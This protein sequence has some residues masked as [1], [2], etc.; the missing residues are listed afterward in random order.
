MEDIKVRIYAFLSGVDSLVDLGIN[1]NNALE[2]TRLD[3]NGITE[4]YPYV[5]ASEPLLYFI[6]QDS[7]RD[8]EEEV[9]NEAIEMKNVAE[10]VLII[11]L[12][13]IRIIEKVKIVVVNY[14][15]DVKTM[16]GRLLKINDPDWEKH[17]SDLQIRLNGYQPPT[18]DQ[19]PTPPPIHEMDDD[20]FLFTE[21]RPPVLVLYEVLGLTPQAT[22]KEIRTAYKNL[23][24]KY[25][26]DKG[27]D[28]EQFILIENA[29]EVLSDPFRK[30]EYDRTGT[31]TP[32]SPQPSPP[33]PQPSPPPPQPSPPPPPPTMRQRNYLFET[34]RRIPLPAKIYI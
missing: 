11:S 25:H 1:A 29:Y 12:N 30:E 22:E 15:D 33:S 26:P 31:Y 10:Q 14:P 4:F 5:M 23:A 17:L 9:L 28:T 7:S 18:F 2:F 13:R 27:G 32:P 24:K 16:F 3:S 19:I 20:D 8:D 34:E 21:P 6:N